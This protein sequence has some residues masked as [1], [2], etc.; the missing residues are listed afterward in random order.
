[1]RS[2]DSGRRMRRPSRTHYGLAAAS[3]IGALLVWTAWPGHRADAM[4]ETADAP[5]H[6]RADERAQLESMRLPANVVVKVDPSNRVATSAPA[7]QLGK[8]LFSDPRFSRN[9]AIACASCHTPDRQ[10]EDGR[11]LAIGLGIGV[12][13]T[14][15]VV[16]MTDAPWLFWDGR[17]DSMWSQAIGPIEDHNEHGGT[18]LR[19]A[20][21]LAEHY[22]DAYEPLFGP[23]PDLSALPRDGGPLGTDAEKAV[24]QRLDERTRTDVSRVFANLGKA[25]AAYEATLQYGPSRFDTYVDGV[26]TGDPAKLAALTPTEKAGLRLFVNKGQCM[27]CH[28]G[29]MLSDRQFHNIGVP[30]RSGTAADPGRAAAVA[31]VLHDEFNCMGPFSDA[32]PEQCDEL[33]FISTDDPHMLGAFKTPS[34][35]NVAL[36]PPYMHAGQFASLDAVMRHYADAPAA[37]IGHSELKRIALSDDE[38]RQLVALLGAFSGPIVER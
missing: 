26:R 24:W 6:W 18:R 20:H 29:P 8:R 7:A 17:K 16:G 19:A 2:R 22:R 31:K 21:V 9:G 11:P 4:A 34:L 10:F 32:K 13:R 12:R 3:M 38:Q 23:L 35:R 33:Q 37:A 14:M 15:P 1:M 36:R 30:P 28:T 27:T 25:I 5:D